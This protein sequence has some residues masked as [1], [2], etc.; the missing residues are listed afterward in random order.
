MIVKQRGLRN[1]NPGNIR[2][3]GESWRGEVIGTD[4]AFKSFS[5]APWGYR[6]MF[7]L[8]DNYNRKYGCKTPAQIVGRWAPP[9]ENDTNAYTKTVS[10]LAKVDPAATINTLDQKTMLAL[11][12]AMSRVENGIDAVEADVEAGWVLFLANH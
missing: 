8:I 6:A 4:K 12:S 1:N 11:V 7:M 3:N 10:E 9:T 5:S 2:H